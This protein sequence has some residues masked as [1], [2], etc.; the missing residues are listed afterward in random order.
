MPDLWGI[1]DTNIYEYTAGV[2]TSKGSLPASHDGFNQLGGPFCAWYG[3]LLYVATRDT[4][5]TTQ[6]DVYTWDPVTGDWTGGTGTET[7]SHAMTANLAGTTSGCSMIVAEG[8]LHLFLVTG[9][10]TA[11]RATYDGTSWT[12]TNYTGVTGVSSTNG[13]LHQPTYFRGSVY[14]VAG[15]SANGNAAD[16]SNVFGFDVDGSGVT[17]VSLAVSRQLSIGLH[18]NRLFIVEILLT[19]A[20]PVIKH[21]DGA[22]LVT[23]TG[24]GFVAQT[25]ARAAVFTQT[26]TAGIR[27]FVMMSNNTG[28]T[29]L[30]QS[31]DRGE[32][33]TD[34]STT[35]G[36]PNFLVEKYLSVYL[37]DTE[38]FDASPRQVYIAAVDSDTTPQSIVYCWDGSVTGFV[39]RHTTANDTG[40]S[41][42]WFQ[43]DIPHIRIE[44]ALDNKDGTADIDYKIYDP[45]SS[46]CEIEFL[47]SEDQGATWILCSN[48]AAADSSG[49]DGTD[50]LP[51][52][53]T[54]PLTLIF[55]WNHSTDGV[56]EGTTVL[57][58]GI[59]R[60]T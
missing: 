34:V 11:T 14:L 56:A 23:A 25:G 30:Y 6:I 22:S 7:V 32:N 10:A 20:V 46:T 13:A 39:L 55:V 31:S 9:N 47:F 1:D 15:Q 3:G 33:W 58:K 19:S 42:N 57:I 41:L 28:Q 51:S 52:H 17:L 12:E 35:F 24:T 37:D 8:K 49:H 36:A 44:A 2:E 27:L 45:N 4:V 54:A 60:I 26:V 38:L 59:A 40:H 50:N 18:D 21:W 43:D 5:D 48:P 16:A 29:F 53:P